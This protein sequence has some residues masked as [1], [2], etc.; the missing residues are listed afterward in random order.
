MENEMDNRIDEL[1]ATAN[2]IQ[3]V[4][5]KLIGPIISII[6]PL[7]LIAMVAYVAFGGVFDINNLADN[8]N[9]IRIPIVLLIVAIPIGYLIELVGVTA[10]LAIILAVLVIWL[11]AGVVVLIKR[12]KPAK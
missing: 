5:K 2:K 7:V 11:V 4:Y 9:V 12:L 10:G 8:N 1:Q 3:H 6:I